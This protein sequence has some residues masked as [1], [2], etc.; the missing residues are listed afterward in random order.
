MF[1]F[2]D[3]TTD[4]HL[5]TFLKKLNVSL[6]DYTNDNIEYNKRRQ[7]TGGT[8]EPFGIVSFSSHATEDR[9]DDAGDFHI[10]TGGNP[11]E[12][13]TNGDDE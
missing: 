10:G 8:Q 11:Q 13:A 4:A 12:Q 6:A 3:I 9:D 2:V 7:H 1:V 5:M